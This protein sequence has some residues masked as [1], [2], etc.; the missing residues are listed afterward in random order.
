M[1]LVHDTATE[2]ERELQKIKKTNVPL[3][4]QINDT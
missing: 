3:S 4:F 1:H 2:K